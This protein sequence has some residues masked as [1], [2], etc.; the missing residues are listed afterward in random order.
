M[1]TLDE[2][3]KAEDGTATDPVCKMTAD[4]ASPPGGTAEHQGQTY[5]FCGA[6]C[7]LAFQA[8]PGKFV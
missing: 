8:E 4:M 7:R 5:Y 2:M 3:F 1:T 6:G